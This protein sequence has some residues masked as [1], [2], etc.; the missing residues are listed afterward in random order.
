MGAGKGHR[1]VRR[2]LTPTALDA[3]GSRLHCIDYGSCVSTP[4]VKPPKLPAEEFLG[5]SRVESRYIELKLTFRESGSG[6]T[7]GTVE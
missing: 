3:P 7:L 1:R 5:L 6:H 2:S 4:K